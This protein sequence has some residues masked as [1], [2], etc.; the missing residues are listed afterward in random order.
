MLGEWFRKLMSRLLG[1]RSLRDGIAKPLW[2]EADDPRERYEILRAYYLN[3]GLYETVQ[4][5]LREGGVWHEAMRALR[6]PAFRVAEFYVAKLWPGPLADALPIVADNA[7][8]LA[9]IRQVWAWSNWG[10]QKQVAARWLAMY[11]DLFVKVVEAGDRSRVYFELVDPRCVTDF[12]A[13]ERG[14]LTYVRL[15]VPQSRREGDRVVRF[16]HTEVWTKDDFRLWAH[17]RGPGESIERLGDPKE[18]KPLADFG[19]DFVPFVH[20]KLRDVG[21]KRGVAAITPA[22]DKIDEANRQ[23][24]RLHQILFN[25]NDVLWALRANAMDPTGR[26]IPPP[27]I[28]GASAG[29]DGDV[30]ELGGNRLLRLPGLSE[31]QSLVPNLNY[32]SALGILN[33]MMM[34]LEKDLPELAY[35]RLRDMGELSGRAVRLL[36]SDAIDRV[37]EARGNAET[38]LARAD[39]MAL[40]IGK[41]AGLEGFAG[42]GSYED[43]DFAHTFAERE[44]IPVSQIERAEAAKTLVDAGVPLKTALRRQGWSDEELAQLELD[45]AEQE[46]RQQQT[47]AAAVLQAQRQFERGA[48]DVGLAQPQQARPPEQGE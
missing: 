26:P 31:L 1:L 34:E 12:D 36:L 32:D 21:E 41:N 9:P 13:N 18:W 47:L 20:A 6:N 11:G 15:D 7:A 24:T 48:A 2:A 19:I 8:I 44:V 29:Q 5:A 35:Y 46:A 37:I 3:N 30:V 28:K 14:Y 25:Y 33:A 10:A 23:A 39:A 22:L 42:I 40:T 45:L 27:R 4:L 38:A 17:D 16:T 43:G